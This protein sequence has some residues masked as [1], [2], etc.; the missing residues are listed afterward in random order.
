MQIFATFPGLSIARE[1]LHMTS[2]LI[3][4]KQLIPL[5][6]HNLPD[7]GVIIFIRLSFVSHIAQY[8]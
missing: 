8:K 2:C 6:R 4:Q 7:D 3:S 5:I 1:A